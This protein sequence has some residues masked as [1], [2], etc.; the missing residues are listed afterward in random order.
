LDIPITLA[1]GFYNNLYYRTSRDIRQRGL[2]LYTTQYSLGKLY[3]YVPSPL[4]YLHQLQQ[5]L[6]HTFVGYM[7]EY[8]GTRR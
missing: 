5:K 3:G 2:T 1:I 6:I 4:L 8:Y 7:A